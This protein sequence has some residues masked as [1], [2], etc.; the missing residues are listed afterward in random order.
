MD[1]F[2]ESILNRG[3]GKPYWV[4]E[5]KPGG[6]E[7]G[8]QWLGRRM[9]LAEAKKTANVLRQEYEWLIEERTRRPAWLEGSQEREINWDWEE[10]HVGRG[11]FLLGILIFM[12]AY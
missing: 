5:S 12:D 7:R 6:L 10:G 8:A 9:F 2:I 3:Q 1:L 11:G 4:D